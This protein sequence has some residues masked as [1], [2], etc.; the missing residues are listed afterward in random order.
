MKTNKTKTLKKANKKLAKKQLEQSLS[1]RF[2]EA[3]RGIGHN[4]EI[5]ADDIAK[6]SK[7][8]AKKLAKKFEEV[9]IAVEH[10]LEEQQP[11]KTKKVKL[12][13]KDAQKLMKKVDKSVSKVVKKAVKK[14]TPAT[15]SVKVEPINSADKVATTLKAPAKSTAATKTATKPTVVKKSVVKA[16]ANNPVTKVEK[17][18][19]PTKKNTNTK[20]N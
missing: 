1:E 4:A 7:A 17:A 13:K 19:I 12:A 14:S 15:A 6:L 8:A 16:V 2:F 5:I 3:V 10:K 11:I 20:K 18:A 9:K